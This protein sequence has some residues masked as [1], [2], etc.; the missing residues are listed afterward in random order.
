MRIAFLTSPGRIRALAYALASSQ[1]PGHEWVRALDGDVP[2]ADV[3]VS[4][5][6]PHVVPAERLDVPAFNV[7]P[8][9]PEFPGQMPSHFAAYEGSWLA[10]ATLHRM[11]A[12]VDA[13]EIL[14]VWERPVDPAGGVR[15]LAE[16][17]QQLALGV[18]LRNLDGMLAGTLRPNGRA[19]RTGAPRTMADFRALARIEPG[20]DA[21]ELQR[22]LV[23]LAS[24]EHRTPYVELH[25]VRFVADPTRAPGVAAG[26]PALAAVETGGA[27]TAGAVRAFLAGHFEEELAALGMPAELPEHFDL[28]ANGVVDSFGVLELIA[29]IEERFGLDVDFEELDPED[30]TVVGPFCRFV[31]AAAA[32]APR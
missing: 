12:A 5:L 21:D 24:P 14:D 9:T 30:L 29:A 16:F 19:W 27:V 11:I 7:H 20:I 28:H 26:P 17:S 22:R 31:E 4:F 10:G 32:S 3:L 13:G 6:N 15:G 18:L 2:E 23:A 25:G 8:G 1:Q